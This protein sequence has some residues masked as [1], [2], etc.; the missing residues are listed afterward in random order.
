MSPASRSAQPGCQPI[1]V[2][3]AEDAGE[4]RPRGR[5]G[6]RGRGRCPRSGVASGAMAVASF[7]IQGAPSPST[8]S[9]RMSSAPRRRASAA[10][11][12]AKW[13]AGGEAAQVAG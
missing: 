4:A 8:T 11:R 9:W 10:T 3:V 12:V 1:G 13:S 5:A 6:V 7:Q 2:G